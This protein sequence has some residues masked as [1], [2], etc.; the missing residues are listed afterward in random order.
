[1]VVSVNY[2]V[3]VDMTEIDLD[4]ALGPIANIER[5]N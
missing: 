1:M 5:R 4:V 2:K 3:C